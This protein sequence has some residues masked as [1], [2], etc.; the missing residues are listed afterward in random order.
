MLDPKP[1]S[2]K[3]LA[4]GFLYVSVLAT[5]SGRNDRTASSFWKDTECEIACNSPILLAVARATK[6]RTFFVKFL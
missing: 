4:T 1:F 5:K 3:D 2:L 6:K